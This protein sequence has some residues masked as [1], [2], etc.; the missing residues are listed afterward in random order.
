MNYNPYDLIRIRIN[1]QPTYG[2]PTQLDSTIVNQKT[3]TNEFGKIVKPSRIVSTCVQCGHS[4]D[5]TIRLNDPPFDIVD[6]ICSRCKPPI[7]VFHDPF[8]NPLNSGR[9]APS[10]LDT[11]AHSPRSEIEIIEKPAIQKLEKIAKNPEEFIL[12][13]PPEICKKQRKQK[14]KKSKNN[15]PQNQKIVL[16]DQLAEIGEES[17]IDDDF[18]DSSMVDLK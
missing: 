10:H 15:E 13:K 11:L 9:I 17:E 7:D 2:R 8:L 1:G 6:I 3:I 16:Q 14:K 18:D 4:V 5:A 12:N